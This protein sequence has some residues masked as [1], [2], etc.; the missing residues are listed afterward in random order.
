MLPWRERCSLWRSST[1][2]FGRCPSPYNGFRYFRHHCVPVLFRIGDKFFL[3]SSCPSAV[4]I[5]VVCS[6]YCRFL[7]FCRYRFQLRPAPYGRFLRSSRLQKPIYEIM[8]ALF[9]ATILAFTLPD[10]LGGGN[11]LVD[12]LAKAR[13]GFGFLAALLLAKFLFTL[14]SYGCGVPGGFSCLFSS[15]APS[16]APWRGNSS[17]LQAFYPP[18]TC[19]T[20]LS[21]P[22]SL[23]L[24]P[25]SALPLRGRS[26]FWNDR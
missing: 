13:Y 26:S 16:S 12:S 23:S 17:S 2:I 9:A 8:F 1:A 24:P 20:L 18:S 7:R 22:W 14:I 4:G 21:L 11:F 3:S 6:A 5:L 10:V 15:S 25:V 19:Q